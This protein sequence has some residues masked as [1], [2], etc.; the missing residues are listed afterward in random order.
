MDYEKLFEYNNGSK[1]LPA[2]SIRV[3]PS[4]IERFF[5]DKTSWYRELLLGEERKFKSSTSTI[6][7]TCIH[8]A[9]EVVALAKIKGTSHNSAAL[10]EAVENYIATFDNDEDY[11]TDEVRTLWH[12]MAEPLIKEY[13]LPYN[14]IAVENFIKYEILPNIFIAGTYDAITSTVPN[15]DLYN[16]KGLLT[17]RDYKSASKKPSSFS[18]AYKLQAYTYAYILR[19]QGIKISKVELCYTIRPTKAK[20]SDY[21]V[22]RFEAPFDEQAYDFIEGILKLIADSIQC[23]QDYE[24]LRYLLSCDYRLKKGDIP[25]P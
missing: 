8:V 10:H 2:N 13:V 23:F 4:N 5:S 9:A 11:N 1:E 21:R 22:L 25:R 6:L 24:D 14:I 18:Y 16:P 20:P 12:N 3:S 19:Q 7:G 15:D 17:L